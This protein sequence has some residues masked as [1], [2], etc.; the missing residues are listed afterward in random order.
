METP[1]NSMRPPARIVPAPVLDARDEARRLVSAAEQHAAEL[2]DDAQHT[3]ESIR[4][5]ARDAGRDE[6]L[7]YAQRL[8]VEIQHTRLRTLEGEALRR[9]VSELA[10]AVTR[11]VLGEAW[12]AVPVDSGTG[13]PRRRGAAAAGGCPLAPGVPGERACGARWARDRDFRWLDRRRRGRRRRRGG[14]HRG[15]QL[16]PGGRPP[17]DD[18]RLVPGTARPRGAGVSEAPLLDAV[19]SGP[20]LPGDRAGG[21]RPRAPARGHAAG[22]A[23]RGGGDHPGRAGAGA[24]RGRRLR[25]LAGAAASARQRGRVGEGAEVASR[26]ETLTVGVGQAP[27]RAGA[28]RAGRPMDGGPPPPGSSPG[29]SIA[30]CPDRFRRARVEVPLPLG[31]RAIDG[32]LTVGRGQRLGLFAG[33]GVGKSTLLGQIA[34]QTQADVDGRRAGGRARPRAARVR[35]GLAGPGG[36]AAQRGRV[37]DQRRARPGAPPG[38]VRRHRHRRVVPRPG[39][40]RDVH[41]R[42]GHPP[43]AR[44]ARGGPRRRRAARAPGLPAQR[45]LDAPAAARAHRQLGPRPLHRAL[46]RARGRRRHGGAHRRRGPRHPRRPLH[47]RPAA[48]GAKPAGPP[49]TCSPRS[50]A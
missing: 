7:A 14:L 6:G 26:G 47:P 49:W 20:P 31:I 30:A 24:R 45:V 28:R 36:P 3:A 48:G 8:L 22:C 10:L 13:S 23:G 1:W 5:A 29:R 11:R 16:G 17:L 19:R 46:H 32:L 35:R 44:A 41:A 38:R 15:L 50:R 39:R 21:A 34:R 25:R 27:R 4:S 2:V 43:G 40:E 12:E 37:R 9:S 42:L 33:S 18:A